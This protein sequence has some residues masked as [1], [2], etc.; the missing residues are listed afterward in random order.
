MTYLTI[1]PVGHGRHPHEE[2]YDDTKGDIPE[3][4]IMTS[5]GEIPDYD[6]IS[7]SWETH[8]R[9]RLG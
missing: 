6:D 3:G 9:G 8:L 1:T 7:A 2:D 5:M 4:K